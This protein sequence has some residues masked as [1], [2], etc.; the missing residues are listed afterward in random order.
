M[1]RKASPGLPFLFTRSRFFK[2]H[3]T[4][5][6]L[7]SQFVNLTF[8][9]NKNFMTAITDDHMKEMLTKSRNYSVVI[10]K[11][12]PKYNRPDLQQIVWEHARRNFQLRADGPLS[13][14]CPVID[15]SDVKGIGIFNASIEETKKIMNE[16]PGVKENVFVFEVHPCRSFP[17]DALP[18]VN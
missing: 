4:L 18:V 14:V 8:E 12:G 10:L 5:S 9:F 16:D 3:L 13:I 7:S 1:Q 15:G 6:K 2:R 11:G 17:G